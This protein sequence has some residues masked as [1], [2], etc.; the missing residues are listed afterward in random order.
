MFKNIKYRFS[1]LKKVDDKQRTHKIF[2]IYHGVH[3]TIK[4]QKSAEEVLTSKDR[5]YVNE[6][7][8]SLK[9]LA[10]AVP[11]FVHVATS[12]WNLLPNLDPTG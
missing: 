9:H 1:G 3:K 10:S 11:G 5:H 4:I 2:T 12:T 6:V 7:P 8:I